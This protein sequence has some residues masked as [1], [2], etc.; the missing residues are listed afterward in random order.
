MRI[1]LATPLYPPQIGGPAT[2]AEI[3]VR[4][5]PKHGIEADLLPFSNVLHLPLIVRHMVYV[6]K[7]ITRARGARVIYALDP[8][9]VGFPAALVSIL[10]QTPLV[11]RIAGDHAWEQ[12]RQRYGVTESLDEFSKKTNEYGA[13]I[14]LYKWI[15][16]CTASI[17]VRI[18]VPSAYMKT[19]VSNWG[20]S[21]EKIH[22]VYSSFDESAPLPKKEEARK[23]LNLHGTIILSVGRLV[24]WKGFSFLIALMKEI[25]IEFPDARLVI[26][27]DGPDR[28][29]LEHEAKELG[30]RVVFTGQLSHDRVMRYLAA[31]DLFVLNTQYEG[32]SHQLLEALYA[33]VPVITTHVGGNPEV[34]KDGMNGLLVSWNDKTAFQS[35]IRNILNDSALATGLTKAGSESLY[36]FSHNR[37]VS[38]IVALLEHTS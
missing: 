20:I 34:I 2:H 28:Q 11:V 37:M 23:I 13:M 19:I 36:R 8:V 7:A 18:I 27:G 31:A 12:G 16:R 9:S 10:T 3:L 35:A 1:L 4:E 25:G 38:D 24:P 22:V 15:E 6:G 21:P 5:L 30:D 26:V 14:R 29:L 17:A 32:L 33:E